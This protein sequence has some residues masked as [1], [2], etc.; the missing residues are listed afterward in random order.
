[1][2]TTTVPSL[3]NRIHDVDTTASYSFGNIL[4][5]SGD[6]TISNLDSSTG[7]FT[8]TAPDATFT[9]D[10]TVQYSV[11]DG[12]NSTTGEVSIV[13]APLITQP[14][15]VTELDHQSS[16]SLTILNLVG[17]VQDV[18]SNAS[19]TFSNL[20]LVDGGGSVAAA[21]FADSS[22]GTFTYNLPAAASPHPVHIGYTVS[23]GTNTANGVV[24]LQLV[25]IDVSSANFA[26]LQNTTSTLPA[27]NGRILDVKAVR[28]SLFPVRQFRRATAPSCSPTRRRA[29][30]AT[31]RP[32]RRSRVRFRS[33]RSQRRHELDERRGR[34]DRGALVTSPLLIPVAVQTGPSE[35]PSLVADGNV[36]DIASHPTYTFSKPVIAPGDGSVQFTNATT[37]TL[38]YTPPSASF[39]GVVQVSV[40]CHGRRSELREWDCDHQCRRDDPPEE[41]RP[42]RGGG[43]K[44]AHD[45]GLPAL[46]QRRC[47]PERPETLD[48]QCGK[49]DE[50]EGGTQCERVGHVHADGRWTGEL[51][52][53]GHGCRS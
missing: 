14:V 9:G 50:R 3:L 53:C 13:V 31:P 43:G 1:M 35:L 16:V 12:T 42:D 4:I 6:G 48:R 15:T 37:G 45:F 5:P 18:S 11:S 40:H 28:R 47:L 30:S 38:T 41:R 2:P 34:P 22:V 29:S 39:F 17:A 26:V 25:G 27:L 10:V 7:S 46:G 20:R 8:Y 51:R 19:Y 33:I 49:R 24:T 32:V 21:G 44:A 36:K 23:D 52:L